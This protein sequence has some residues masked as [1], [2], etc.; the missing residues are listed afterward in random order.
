MEANLSGSTQSLPQANWAAALKA[1]WQWL[2]AAVTHRRVRRLR[3]NETLSLGDRRF[4]AIIEFDRQEFL[5]AGCGNSLELLAR[6][7]GGKL[8]AEPAP[9]R[10]SSRLE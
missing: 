7:D 9:R 5:L 8:I 2:R 4:L 3:I 1:T 10:A 6:L